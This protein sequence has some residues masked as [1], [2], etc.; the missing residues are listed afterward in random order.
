MIGWNP[1][2]DHKIHE[3]MWAKNYLFVEQMI[4]R[5]TM[6]VVVTCDWL[7]VVPM[8]TNVLN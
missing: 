2:T 6:I 3:I 7:E 5:S 1:I 8:T 4:E